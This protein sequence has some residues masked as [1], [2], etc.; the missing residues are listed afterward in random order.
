MVPARVLAR[1]VRSPKPD[2]DERLAVYLETRDATD[3]VVVY[4]ITRD[5][6]RVEPHRP[7]MNRTR[8]ADQHEAAEI[9]QAL[10]DLGEKVIVQSGAHQKYRTWE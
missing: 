6:W 8:R 5:Q 10:L 7:L 9:H 3:H 1:I 2:R 4:S